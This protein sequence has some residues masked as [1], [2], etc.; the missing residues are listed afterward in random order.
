MFKLQIDRYITTIK[1]FHV[2]PWTQTTITAAHYKIWVN[3]TQTPTSKQSLSTRKRTVQQ[4]IH[5]PQKDEKPKLKPSKTNQKTVQHTTPYNKHLQ[6]KQ[7]K[8]RG[9]NLLITTKPNKKDSHT[10]Y[11]WKPAVKTWFSS[12]QT[13]K[14]LPR[15][16]EA[17]FRSWSGKRDSSDASDNASV[18]DCSLDNHH[19]YRKR[20][21]SQSLTS[22]QKLWCRST[23]NM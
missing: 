6:L 20:P 3:L 23:E 11:R 18:F 17:L 8:T 7:M 1:I 9:K 16:C 10:S 12:K 22:L 15:T 14:R 19:D 2:A 21:C 5:T 4:T 13:S